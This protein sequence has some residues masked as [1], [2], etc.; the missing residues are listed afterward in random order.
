[1]AWVRVLKDIFIDL[2][3]EKPSLLKNFIE[4]DS[5]DDNQFSA[6]ADFCDDEF[7]DNDMDLSLLSDDTRLLKKNTNRPK[8]IWNS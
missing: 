3:G 2:S 4:K 8:K 5:L 1:M 7:S 6:I